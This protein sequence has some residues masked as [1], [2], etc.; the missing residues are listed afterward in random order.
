MDFSR[1]KTITIEHLDFHAIISQ[2][3]GNIVAES[4]VPEMLRKAIREGTDVILTDPLGQQS[5]RLILTN[6]GSFQY[7]P[8]DRNSL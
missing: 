8:L 3:T 4:E 2:Q 6:D 7:A 1:V 5:C